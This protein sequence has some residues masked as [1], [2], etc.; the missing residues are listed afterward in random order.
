MRSFL[1]NELEPFSLLIYVLALLLQ[2]KHHRSARYKVLCAY[3]IACAIVIY[4]GIIWF[5][6]NTWTYNLLFFTHTLFL[7]W[8]Y[9]GLFNNEAKK[10]LCYVSAI[11]CS[12]LF[13]YENIIQLRYNNYHD[14]VY[15][16]SYIVIV[17]YALLYL[18]QLVLNQKEESLLSNFDFWLTCGYLLY[19]LGTFFII[20]YYDHFRYSDFSK[21][22]YTRGDI[23][24][25]HNVI[26]FICAAITLAASIQSAKKSNLQHV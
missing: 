15:G 26:L 25:V 21:T 20:L 13:V 19:F 17:L 2:A 3:Y 8:Y 12:A 14:Y 24:Q 22:Y 23:W 10:K 5:D 11:C 9:H 18:H 16:I 4:I 1:C 7:S 6:D